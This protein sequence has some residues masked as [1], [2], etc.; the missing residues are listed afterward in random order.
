M[1]LQE[2]GLGMFLHITERGI[3]LGKQQNSLVLKCVSIPGLSRHM[4]LVSRYLKLCTVTFLLTSSTV[5]CYNPLILFPGHQLL[6]PDKDCDT[7]VEI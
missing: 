6:H 5:L 2:C 1:R 7:V 4:G 3:G